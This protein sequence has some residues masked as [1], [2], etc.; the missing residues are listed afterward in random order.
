MGVSEVE[1]SSEIYSG[2]LVDTDGGS[3]TGNTYNFGNENGTLAEVKMGGL[4]YTWGGDNP[5]HSVEYEAG[6]STIPVG[7][8]SAVYESSNGDSFTDWQVS[9]EM[10]FMTTAFT[11]W[12]GHSIDS[13]P[14]FVGYASAL[15]SGSQSPASGGTSL[16]LLVSGVILVAIVV[17]VLV[18]RR[19]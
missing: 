13:D 14:V 8:F 16:L 19:R 18:R 3:V 9:A 4:T 17:L 6:S 1:I 10:L 15:G 12:G 2:R 11:N 7:V 5:P